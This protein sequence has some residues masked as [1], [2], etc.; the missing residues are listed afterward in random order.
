MNDHGCVY[1]HKFECHIILTYCK[2]LFFQ[3]Y[4]QPFQNLKSHYKETGQ[5]ANLVQGP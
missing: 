2:I 3:L 5:K 4:P 1:E